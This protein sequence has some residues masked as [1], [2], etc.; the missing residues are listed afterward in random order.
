MKDHRE[1]LI[2]R[3]KEASNKKEYTRENLSVLTF[4]ELKRLSEELTSK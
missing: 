2:S 3:I 1:L 4:E